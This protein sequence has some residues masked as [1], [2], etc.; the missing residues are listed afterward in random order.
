MKIGQKCYL[1]EQPATTFD[2]IPPKSLFPKDFQHKGVKVPACSSCNNDTSKD[3]EY[4]RDYFA[5]TGWNKEARQVFIEKVK[6]SYMRP[7]AMTQP[8][9]KHQRILNSM[10]KVDIKTPNGIF[11][12]KATAMRM[13]GDRI[14]KSLKKIIKGIYFYLYKKSIP[15]NYSLKVY[16]QPI[17]I[18][19]DLLNEAK[20]S[21]ALRVGRY[22]NSFSYMGFIAKEDEFVGVWW[23]SFYQT[24]EAIIMIDSPNKLFG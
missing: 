5:M 12:K 16:F 9:T 11:L 22:G 1:C 14:E 6:P 18:G 17:D 7:Y 13:K 10:A 4:L 19:V 20:K 2:H 23:L 3:D 15:D 24:H 8:I 21:G